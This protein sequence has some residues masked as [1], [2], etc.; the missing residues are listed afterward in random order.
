MSLVRQ[1]YYPVKD[2]RLT[3]ADQPRTECHNIGR[4][5]AWVLVYFASATTEEEHDL[6]GQLPN[7]IEYLGR[8]RRMHNWTDFSGTGSVNLVGSRSASRRPGHGAVAETISIHGECEGGIQ[9]NRA[10]F[11]REHGAER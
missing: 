3:N 8:G 7:G 4:R 9:F 5:A 2:Y 6:R 10:G 11:R 1:P